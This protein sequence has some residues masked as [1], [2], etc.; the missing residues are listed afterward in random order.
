MSM[1]RV[2]VHVSIAG[3]LDQAVVRAKER[4]CDCFQI[5]TKNPRGWAAKEITDESASSFISATHD[6]GIA[7]VYAHMPYLPN[8]AS[9]KYDLYKKSVEALKAEVE[10]CALLNI[11]YLVTHAGHAG[12]SLQEGQARVRDAISEVIDTGEKSV[13][14]LL[15]N[16][17]GERN[18]VGSSLEDIREI[19]DGIS[20][21]VRTGFCFDTCHAFVAGYELRTIEAVSSLSRQITDMLGDAALSLIHLNDAKGELGSARDRHEHIGCGMIGRLGMHAILHDT[22]LRTIPCICETPVDERRTDAE[23]IAIVREI[24]KEV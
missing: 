14:I 22:Y 21:P 11:P 4:G 16:T 2:G 10:R 9:E 5:F 24:A 13:R 12:D 7:P 23:N 17:A 1:I 15:E 20:D 6:A 18:S 19:L 8:L 3:S